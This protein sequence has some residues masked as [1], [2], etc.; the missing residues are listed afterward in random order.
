MVPVHP[1]SHIEDEH[2][3]SL[4]VLRGVLARTTVLNDFEGNLLAFGE[5]VHASALDGGDVDENVRRAIVGLDEAVTLGGIEELHGTSS[6]DDILSIDKQ[7]C[8]P[9]DMDRQTVQIDID[10]EDRRA[11]ERGNKVR[12]ARSMMST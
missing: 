9:V 11:P 5:A 10:R 2:S 1:W 3:C 6:H 4:Q 7:K 12:Q 8:P